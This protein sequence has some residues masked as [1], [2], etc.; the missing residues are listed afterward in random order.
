MDER[1]LA[2]SF[3]ANE[4][5]GG[6]VRARTSEAADN[7]VYANLVISNEA[8]LEARPDYQA[9]ARLVMAAGS[10]REV[11]FTGMVDTVTPG[12]EQTNVV[13]VSPLQL[14]RESRSAGLGVGAGTHVLE[15]VWS[16]L[17]AWGVEAE[18]IDFP[19]FRPPLEVFE[20]ATALDGVNIEEPVSIGR[21]RLLPDGD[22]SR[23]ADGLGP[24]ELRG[25]YSGA[26][27]YALVLQNAKTLFE[28]ESEG[29]AAI[30]LALAW[31]TARTHYSSVALPGGHPRAFQRAWTRSRVSRREAV[32]VRGVATGRRWLRSPRDVHD[33][34]E[35][36]P[37]EMD[38]LRSLPLPPD[39]PVVVREALSAWR[40]ADEET[41]PLAAVV[42]LWEAVEF[43]ASG[44]KAPKVFPDKAVRRS[45]GRRATEGLE[46]DQRR[47]VEDVLG[48]LNQPPLL[49]R[50]KAALEADGV[51][52]TE[53]ELA[54]L[55]R[56]R[57]IRNDLVH[58]R[59][60]EA[61]RGQDLKYGKAVVNRMLVY[62][63]SSLAKPM[64]TGA[65]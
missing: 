60:K 47:R 64:T 52:Y 39:L 25:L 20:V 23:L 41:D 28:A 27:A 15:T 30:D 14:L 7:V 6:V 57:S 17:R 53:E 5:V 32:V 42:A 9:E 54:L 58:G 61:P 13:L 22:V 38:D 37:A 3:G 55:Q 49:V 45:L 18:R 16:L 10:E 1:Q 19:Q 40:R 50:L 65:E 21:V 44:A 2:V 11:V 4:I 34:P 26:P 62:R 46:G 8:L 43:Y 35:L 33:R 51:P 63:V 24:D 56:L 36:I 59:S 31:L 12:E 29:V 48:M